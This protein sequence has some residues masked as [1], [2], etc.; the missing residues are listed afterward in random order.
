M[1]KAGHGE[2]LDMVVW[3]EEGLSHIGISTTKTFKQ[4]IMS[5]VE[6]GMH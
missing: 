3:E 6:S 5:F 4:E 1:K 2:N